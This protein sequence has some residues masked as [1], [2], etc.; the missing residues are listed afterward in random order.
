METIRIKPQYST[1]VHNS[2]MIELRHGVWNSVSHM[3]ND[4]NEE[5]ILA[6][7][8]LGLNKQSTPAEIAN[9]IGISR[10]KVESV[11]DYLQQLGVLQAKSESFIDYYV[12]NIAPTL[13]RPGQFHYQVSMPI[14]LVGDAYINKKIREQLDA[15]LD[16]EMI[17]GSSLWPLIQKSGDDW[18]FDALEQQR[19]VEQFQMWK[20]KFIIFSSKHI[21]PILATRLNRIA[22]ELNIPWLHLAID[23]PFIFIGPT[24]HGDHGP[25]YD[26][27]ETRISMN[28]RESDSYQQYK[29]AIAENQVYTQDDDPLLG[30]TSNLLVTHATL[31][32]LNY[33]TTKCSFTSNKTLSIFLPTM[34]FVYHELLRLPSC[35]TCGSVSHRDDTQLYFDFQRL[36]DEVA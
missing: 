10:S 34:E 6:K 15:L 26:C 33:V 22:Y 2:N 18:L 13:R 36:I 19:F 20:G 12:D 9:N 24:F 35:R 25:C 32:I 28:L 21:N 30:V 3:L 4:E 29:N 31:E 16:I 11:L 1:I 7:I 14:V 27:F 23:G 5:G 8:V 17:D